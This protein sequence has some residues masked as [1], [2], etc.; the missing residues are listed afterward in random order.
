MEHTAHPRLALIECLSRDGRPQQSVDVMAWPLE[1]GRAL[2]NHLVLDDPRVAARHARLAPDAEGRLQLSVLDTVNGLRLDGQRLRA[3]EQRALPESGAL[4]QLGDTRLRLRLPGEVLAP[5]QRAPKVV[6]PVLALALPLAALVLA[7]QWI[8]LDPGAPATAWA[9][10]ALGQPLMLVGWCLAWALL[11]KLFHQGFE[12]AAHLR[13]ALGG[14]L[15]LA[16]VDLLLRQLGASLGWPLLWRLSL[17]AQIALLAALF[18]RHLGRVLPG[19]RR[20]AGAALLGAAVGGMGLTAAMNHRQADS[21]SRAAY[22]STLPLPVLRVGGTVPV[23]SLVNDMA[24]LGPP[25]ADRA[26][27]A[28]DE[29]EDELDSE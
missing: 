18:W 16:L 13:I 26:A 17:P 9:S 24:A 7:E 1:I 21:W 6:A 29:E 20:I 10:T 8:E 15:L 14:V 23:S 2:S 11:S 4:L 12:F 27:R 3:G 19:H 25:L 22:M 5:E 28:R